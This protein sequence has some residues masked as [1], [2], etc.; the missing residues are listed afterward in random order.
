MKITFTT[1]FVIAALLLGITK[2]QAQTS[3]TTGPLTWT[4]S[5]DNTTLTISGSGAMPDY[6]YGIWDPGWT[7][8]MNT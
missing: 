7:L 8:F 6:K 1:L 4:V 3:G 2:V 5:S